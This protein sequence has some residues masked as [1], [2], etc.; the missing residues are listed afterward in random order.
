MGKGTLKAGKGMNKGHK[1]RRCRK[2]KLTTRPVVSKQR[3]ID[4]EL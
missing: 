3:I 4:G 2:E 1:E